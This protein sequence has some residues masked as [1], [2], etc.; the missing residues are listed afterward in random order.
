M[1][2]QK[3]LEALAAFTR[4]AFALNEAWEGSEA[5]DPL[6]DRYPF[7]KSFDEIAAAIGEWH[8]ANVEAFAAAPVP[9]HYA[10]AYGHDYYYV[11][12]TLVGQPS[13]AS[14]VFIPNP[15]E[16]T[17]VEDFAEPLTASEL[18]DVLEHLKDEKC[19]TCDEI[20][21]AN[22]CDTTHKIS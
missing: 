17:A 12:D 7:D 22:E 10:G 2:D 4:A 3:T 18:A 14:G 9:K 20:H 13:L 15:D 8:A 11:G 5:G 6:T 19:A 16:T 1:P 21:G